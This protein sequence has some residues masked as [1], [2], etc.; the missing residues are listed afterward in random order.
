MRILRS[1]TKYQAGVDRSQWSI[2]LKKVIQD[3]SLQDDKIVDY[4]QCILHKN[5]IVY[6]CVLWTDLLWYDNVVRVNIV[7]SEIELERQLILIE[8][9]L[10][11]NKLQHEVE[12][13]SRQR[14]SNILLG[15]H[16]EEETLRAKGLLTS[17]DYLNGSAFW[18]A[19]NWNVHATA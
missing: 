7:L 19:G 5:I 15:Q 4:C 18:L 2:D 14:E 1:S 9:E 16:A 8:K 11:V 10:A 12:L 6:S 13:M 3:F 17:W